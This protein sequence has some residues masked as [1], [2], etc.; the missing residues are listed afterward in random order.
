MLNY[1]QTIFS[2]I[3]AVLH[4][5]RYRYFTL[6]TAVFFFIIFL[7]IP[8]I[9]IPANTLKFQLSLLT[10]TDYITLTALA[11]LG[12][13]FLL[14]NIYA[15]KQSRQNKAR[16]GVMAEGGFGGSSVILASIFGAASC[17]MCVVA[18]FGFLG[19]GVVGF[20]VQYQ[21]WILIA[22]LV[23]MFIPLYFTSQKIMGICKKC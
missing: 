13:L 23:L 22:S 11:I 7:A 2:A 21:V 17:P 20:L 16:L 12:S 15:Y 6:P 9:T 8:I 14:M 4:E 18:L 3:K 1:F 10:I 5:R 19:F